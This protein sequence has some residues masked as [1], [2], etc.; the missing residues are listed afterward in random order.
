MTT[1]IESKTT[2]T[3]PARTS[4]SLWFK[5]AWIAVPALI[6]ALALGVVTPYWMRQIF[7]ITLLALLV[8]GLNLSFGWAGELNLGLPAMYAAGAYASGY[9]YINVV[10]DTILGLLVGAVVSVIVGVI[11]GIPGLRLGGW[12][13]GISSFFLVLLIPPIL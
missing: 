11:A 8:S 4:E 3:I 7:L 12:A 5:L 2:M 10:N 6:I 13:L 1:D 9:L